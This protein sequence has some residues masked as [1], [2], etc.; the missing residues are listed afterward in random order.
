MVH[1]SEGHSA[2]TLEW[3]TTALAFLLRYL[4][5]EVG[6]EDP[7]ELERPTP[8]AGSS[9]SA[10]LGASRCVLVVP[11]PP[12]AASGPS[13]PMPVRRMPSANG[14]TKKAS[15]MLTSPTTSPCPRLASPSSASWR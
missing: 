3:H 11:R 1:R 13:T 9:G 5:E 12:H 7:H 8:G 4:T 6:I 2:K 10:H 14:C 15:P